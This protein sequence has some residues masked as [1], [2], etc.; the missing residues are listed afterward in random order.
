MFGAVG[1]GLRRIDLELRSN[2]ADS[3]RDCGEK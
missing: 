2:Q 3:V 1:R